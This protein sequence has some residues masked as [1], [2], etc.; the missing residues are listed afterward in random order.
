MLKECHQDTIL[1]AKIFK[2]YDYLELEKQR[3][4]CREQFK[5]VTRAHSFPGLSLAA[6]LYFSCRG[7]GQTACL[8]CC[9]E[10]GKD[11]ARDSL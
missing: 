8:T 6:L 2:S 3:W 4:Y 1:Q 7:V 10:Q 11:S 9:R 5:V